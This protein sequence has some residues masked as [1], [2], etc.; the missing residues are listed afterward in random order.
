MNAHFSKWDDYAHKSVM[1]SIREERSRLLSLYK[2]VMAADY[3][4]AIARVT[5][6]TISLQTRR[7]SV[8]V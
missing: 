3:S 5:R 8:N 2:A 1:A 6:T 4:L 7:N